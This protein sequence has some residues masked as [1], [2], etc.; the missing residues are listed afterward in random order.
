M[1]AIT[2][3]PSLNPENVPRAVQHDLP[4]PV[5][6]LPKFKV[7]APQP[8]PVFADGKAPK[9]HIPIGFTRPILTSMPNVY[10]TATGF[11]A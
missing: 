3:L 7:P 1:A 5:I 9:T 4:V 6:P 8:V 10:R 11:F 2:P